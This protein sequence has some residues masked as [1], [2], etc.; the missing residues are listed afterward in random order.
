MKENDGGVNL[1]GK[2]HKHICKCHNIQLLLS[3]DKNSFKEIMV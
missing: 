2:Y 3:Y 1:T